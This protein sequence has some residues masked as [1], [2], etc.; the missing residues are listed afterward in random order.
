MS[1]VSALSH[2]KLHT[3]QKPEKSIVREYRKLCLALVDLAQDPKETG[4]TRVAAHRVIQEYV[5]K[6]LKEQYLAERLAKK[7]SA[8]STP[9]SVNIAVSNLPVGSSAQVNIVN[10]GDPQSR[11]HIVPSR[12]EIITQ[13]SSA[14]SLQTQDDSAMAALGVGGE[15]AE[16]AGGALIN[17]H[18]PPHFLDISN[19]LSHTSPETV[20][21]R[22]LECFRGS[23]QVRQAFESVSGYR[24]MSGESSA[25]LPTSKIQSQASSETRCGDSSEPAE[26]VKVYDNLTAVARGKYPA[27][28]CPDCHV[29]WTAKQKE[30][31]ALGRRCLACG[32]DIGGRHPKAVRCFRCSKARKNQQTVDWQVA[33]AEKAEA[34]KRAADANL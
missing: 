3:I 25:D 13:Q 5:I 28:R 34:R 1:A 31:A 30:E 10:T 9:K 29:L 12:K 17:V 21:Q 7:N 4:S 16:K 2:D 22:I 15:A 24:L 33:K 23:S 14:I 20:A 18:I 32:V 11:Q 6:P 19:E 27:R 8:D 26:E